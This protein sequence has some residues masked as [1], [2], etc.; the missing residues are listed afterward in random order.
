MR[1]LVTVLLSL[2]LLLSLM[3]VV[4]SGFCGVWMAINGS[5]VGA[6]IGLGFASVFVAGAILPLARAL[7]RRGEE[8]SE[9]GR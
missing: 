5:F 3:L 8:D 1:A 7:R 2:L 4:G 9:D 6:A